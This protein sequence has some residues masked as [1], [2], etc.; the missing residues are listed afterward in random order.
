VRGGSQLRALLGPP[1]AF[2]AEAG[3]EVK[4]KKKGEGRTRAGSEV[5]NKKDKKT[6]HSHK[7]KK[8]NK[9][10][11]PEN[12]PKGRNWARINTK[13]EKK[14][15]TQGAQGKK[16]QEGE[17]TLDQLAMGNPCCLENNAV[18][19][20]SEVPGVAN[21]KTEGSLKMPRENR[22]WRSESNM[23]LVKSSSSTE[24]AG[25]RRQVTTARTRDRTHPS[26]HKQKD[27]ETDRNRTLRPQQRLG[28]IPTNPA[29]QDP[30][31]LGDLEDGRRDER[32][33][34]NRDNKVRDH[35]CYI[36]MTGSMAHTK[37]KKIK[38]ETGARRSGRSE[39]TPPRKSTS[40]RGREGW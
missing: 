5:R 3:R 9:H 27:T 31:S 2:G 37:V 6:T 20:T 22:A 16:K 38:K 1:E 29:H 17:W 25:K 18:Q 26:S 19:K 14:H 36:W 34:P 7:K 24:G 13:T 33:R 10:R 11:H 32:Q 4:R 8:N 39:R 30:P 40:R 12:K 28:G 35:N 21:K 15:G 23:E